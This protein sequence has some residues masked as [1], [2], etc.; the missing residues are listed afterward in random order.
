M[1][2][3]C[4]N[5]YLVA[6]LFLSEPVPVKKTENPFAIQ[7]PRASSDVFQR[8][9]SLRVPCDE[10]CSDVTQQFRRQMSLTSA[11]PASVTRYQW[12]NNTVAAVNYP[13]VAGKR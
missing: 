9:T 2:L 1:W 4:V 3:K 13:A 10:S 11:D 7:R 5:F 6:L 12:N 8:Q